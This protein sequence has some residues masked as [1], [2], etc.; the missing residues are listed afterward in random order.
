VPPA[1]VGGGWYGA[2]ARTP[3][4]IPAFGGASAKK[5][6]GSPLTKYT[7]Q[8]KVIGKVTWP[9]MQTIWFKRCG[10]YHRPVALPGVLLWL[11]AGMFCL[12]V[13]LAVD[14]HSHSA[15]DTLYGIF[16]FFASTFLLLDWIAG[17][18]SAPQSPGS[19]SVEGS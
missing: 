12:A 17:K 9:P 11:A 10:W 1:G 4:I 7:L 3:T 19:G 13:F 6:G 16:P 14:R 8:C 18:T 5:T 15:S 2:P